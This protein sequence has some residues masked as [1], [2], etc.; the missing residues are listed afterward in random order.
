MK[1]YY[2]LLHVN[3]ESTKAE[4]KSAYIRQLKK[5]HPDIYKGD[6]MF[7]ERMTTDINEA[8]AKLYDKAPEKRVVS[9]NKTTTNSKFKDITNS[10]S[11]SYK[12]NDPKKNTKA[13]SND[14]TNI[15]NKQSNFSKS[16]QTQNYKDEK[17]LKWII[18]TL[19]I[20]VLV[21]LIFLLK[22]AN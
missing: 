6:K 21:G 3:Q 5:Y 14:V 19:S 20:L 16:I 10:A 9:Q 13:T 15:N 7:A 22:F 2:D 18:I 1:K 4:V 11:N 17:I 8:Y 12:S